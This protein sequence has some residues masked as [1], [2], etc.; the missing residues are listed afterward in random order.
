MKYAYWLAL[1]IT[2]AAAVAN[3]RIRC[4]S[5]GC[6][7]L[8]VAWLAWAGGYG[9]TALLGALTWARER[10]PEAKRRHRLCL[11]MQLLAGLALLAYWQ[12]H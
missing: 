11:G 7:G 3:F 5:F 6:M 4:E 10:Q 1:V 9:V 8:G 2:V 12:F